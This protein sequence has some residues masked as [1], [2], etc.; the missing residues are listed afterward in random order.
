MKDIVLITNIIGNVTQDELQ[1]DWKALRVGPVQ[2]GEVSIRKRVVS[3]FNALDRGGDHFC[4]GSSRSRL[5]Y[6]DRSIIS[7]DRDRVFFDAPF[8]VSD[9]SGSVVNDITRTSIVPFEFKGADAAAKV[10]F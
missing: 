9:K 6:L 5:S 2:N 10:L 3:P 8:V 7:S 4:F 1:L